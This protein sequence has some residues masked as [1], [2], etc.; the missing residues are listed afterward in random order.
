MALGREAATES[1]T[2][3]ASS[4]AAFA[5]S[6]PPLALPKGGGAIRG[7]G[8]KFA[9]NPVT[10]T[11]SMTVPI[12]TSPGREGFG[13]QFSLTYDSGSGNGHFG[14]GWSL[15]L[16]AI[17]RKTEKGL[18]QYLDGTDSDI[19]LLSGAEDLVPVYR[20]DPDG[21]W[22]AGRVGYQRDADGFWVRDAQGQLVVHEDEIEGYR[23]RRYR[24]RIEGLFARIEQWSR[25]GSLGDVHWRSISKDNILTLYGFDADSRIADPLDASRIFSWLICE[26]RDDK[27]NAI[28]YL[29][30]KE[31][32][33]WHARPGQAD[34]FAQAHQFNRGGRNALGR[35]AQRYLHRVLYGNRVPLLDTQGQRPR[36]LSN[37]PNPPA[38]S[39]ADW[40]FE[41]RFD[42]GEL[43]ENDPTGQP[44]RS[45]FYRPDAFSSYRSGFEIRTC[46]RCERVLMLHHIPDQPARPGF[47]A[48]AGYQ[49]VVRSTEF[50][51]DDELDPA[52][53]TRPIYSFL[54]QAV[55]AGWKHEGGV[56][57][58]VALPPVEFEYTM[59]EVQDLVEEI[60]AQDLS[61]LPIGL[62]GTAYRWTDL[63]GEGVPGILTEQAGAWFYKRNLGPL[64]NS[65][66]FAPLEVVSSKPN[67][68][69]AGGAE[70]MDLAGDGLPDLVVMEG[71]MSGLYEHDHAGGWQPFK[72]FTSR[73]NRGFGNPN[74]K[75]IDLNGDGHADI[76]LSED[77]AFVWHA[78]LAE[79]GF[80]PARR[81]VKALDEEKG[82]RI[83]FADGTQSIYLADLSGD[84]LTDIVRIRQGEVCYW[85]H[86]GH[87]RF[88]AKVTMDNAPWFDHPDQFDHKRIR[89]ADI[90]GSGT[91]DIIYLH[92]DGVCLYFNQSGNSWSQPQTLKAF[93]RIDDV[94]SIVPLD[95]LGNG[96]ACLVWS[97][98]LPADARRPMRYVNLMGGSKP[99][100][101]VKTTNNLGAETRVAYAP[102]TKFYLQDKFAGKPWIT[103]LPFPVHV[104]ERVETLDHVSRN[105][106]VTRYA[107][108]H[109]YFDGE[110]REFRGFGMIEQ[111]DTEHFAALA[112]GDVPADNIAAESHVPPV[113]TKT[114]F[115]T[116]VYLG[117]NHVSDFF[118]GLLNATDPGEYFREPGLTD[119]E[120]RALLLPDAVMPSGLT[121]EEER[122]ACRALKGSMLRQEVYADDAGPNPTAERVRRASTP[123]TVTE[124]NFT[125]RALQPRGDNRHAVFFTYARE[126]ISFH[127]ERNPADPRIQH[128]LTL[129]VDDYGNVLKQAA[130]GYG[131]R[132]QVRVLD[133]QGRVQLVANPGLAGL[134]ADDQAKQTT[135]L[136]TYTEARFTNPVA[137]DD[138]QR[139]PLPS[140]VITYELTRY[141]ASGPAIGPAAD[142]TQQP[143]RYQALDLVEPDPAHP[144]WLRHRFAAPEVAY[145][146]T[147]VGNQRRRPIE[148]LRTLY[149]RDDLTGLLPLGQ[150]QPL[151]LPGES[152]KLAF[153]PDLVTQV[154][155]RS[156]APL[157]PAPGQVLPTD[158]ANAQWASRG[159]YVDLD[160]NGHWWLPSGRSF[161]TEG[162][163]DNAQAELSAA[164]RHFYLPRRYRDPFG[165]N[166]FVDFDDHDL[167]MVET[168]DALNNR[169]TVDAN[170][171]RVLQSRLVSDPNRN[172]TEVA[173]DTLG[174]VV[175]TAVMGKPLPAPVEG[176]S[177]AGFA[178]DLT[179]AQRA[180]FFDAANPHATAATL[181]H[182]AS[183][184]IVYDL[185]RFRRTRQAT[186][187]DPTKWQPACAAT[188]ARETH[189]NAPLPPQG[190]K[191]QLSFSYSD[192]FGREIQKKI[193]AERGPVPQ[194]DGAG[195]I[196]V[197]ADGQPVMTSNDVSPRWVGSGWTV[198]NNKGKP[199]RQYEP[200]F[201]DT[202]RLD[203]DVRIG[204]SPVLFYDPADRVIATLHPN[205][206]FEKVVFDPWQQTTYDVSDTCAPRPA[207]PG[208]S[209]PAQTGDP[210]TDPDI[211]GT[212]KNYFKSQPATWQTWYAQRIG[213]A[214][215]RDERNAAERAA[216]HADTP[217]TAHFDALGR[218]FLTLARNRVVCA[219]HDLNG[220]EEDVATRVELD[221][222]GNQR[223][224]FD[225]R[226]LPDADNL[227]LGALQQRIVMQY[228]YDM[229]GNRIHQLSMEAGARWMLNDVAGKPIRAWDSRGHN[230]TTKYDALRRP[231]EQT[232]RGTFSDPDPLEPNSDPRTLN[233]DILV[234]KIEYGEPPLGATV[235]QETEAQR[236]NLRTRIYR[237]FDSA[238]VA[239]NARLDAGGRPIEAYDFKGNLLRSTRRLAKSYT[240]IPDWQLDRQ[241]EPALNSQLDTEAFE[242]STRYDARNRP[243]QSIGPH[244]SL[245]RPGHPNNINVIQPVFNEANLLERLDVWLERAS[246]PLTLLDPADVNALPSPVGVANI[247]YD[248]KGQRTLIDY[249]TRDATV[250]RNTYAYD[251]ETFRLTHLYTRRGVNPATAQ[252]VAFTDDCEN[253]NPPPAT[254]AAPERPP[255]GKG[256]GLQNLHYTYDPA[257]NITHIRDDAQQTIY[258]CGVVVEPHNDYEYD[259]LY[260]LIQA[261]GRQ[262]L[263]Q[264]GSPIPHSHDDAGR[265]GAFP[266]IARACGP[267]DG[268][269]MGT[270]TERYV[271]DAVG[272]FLK[273]Q[274]RGSNPAHAG[275]TRA[276]S[277]AA[278][279]LI[280]DGHDGAPVK[281]SN[282]LTRTMLNPAGNTQQPE[283]YA[284]DAHGNM[285]RMPHLTRMA[286]DYRDRL[287]LTSRQ[288]VNETPPPDKIQQTTYY[289]YDASGQRVRKVWEKAPGLIEERIY[290]GGF[291]IFRRHGGSI[292]ANTATLERE[293][294]HVM[295]DK[296]RIALVE[297][298]TLDTAGND[299]APRQQIR[300]QL[301]NQLGSACLELDEDA[302]IISYEEYS[303]YGGSTYQA[304]RSQKE[305]AKRCRY[306]G[307]E[308]DEES[309]LYYHGARYYAAWLGR[310][311][312]CDPVGLVEGP[313][314][315][316][317]VG[318]NPV[319][320]HDP[321]GTEKVKS[322]PDPELIFEFDG[323]QTQIKGVE[324]QNWKKAWKLGRDAVM[325]ESVQFDVDEPS[326]VGQKGLKQ[327]DQ[328]RRATSA[329]N[330]QLLDSTTNRVTKGTRV[331]V[332]MSGQKG[333]PPRAPV[334]VADDAAA[335]FTRRFSEVSE[336]NDLFEQAK[337]SLSGRR[338]LTPVELKNQINTEFR[339][340]IREGTSE[341][342]ARVRTALDELG[343]DSA[344]LRP[345]VQGRSLEMLG[346]G[347]AVVGAFLGGYQVGSG[348]NQ[349]IE[350][351]LALGAIDV[352]EGS[353]NLG[354]SIGTTAAVKSGVLVAEAGAAAG[355]LTVAA[356]AAAAAS[357]ALA[358]E[359]A[360]AAV[361]GEPTPIDVAD[362]YY[363]THFGDIAG[364]VA[365]RYS[366]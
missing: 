31:D 114:W 144:G 316:V 363:G 366:N 109:G 143:R 251:R 56:V 343:W 85:P 358:A 364:W 200:F 186:P 5:V 97:S 43:D 296:Q 276:Y 244:S 2:K 193:Q 322:A 289:V 273:M 272:N 323:E 282:R 301:S 84:G 328:Y 262:H 199:V 352:V 255:A 79:E 16:P 334:S 236:L 119:D 124:Q 336:L 148:R 312:G 145:E 318:S 174:M 69:L 237:H 213:G 70:F 184:R 134:N 326:A 266:P 112:W 139:N 234:D 292:S 94:A 356:G 291:E 256:C 284:H 247:D 62:D 133:A 212:V 221:I 55:Q 90:D 21:T 129:E 290:L 347:A 228:A 223:Q 92:R 7:I 136:L 27:G 71:P 52:S 150:L 226:K 203:F 160:G 65:A 104:V 309:G 142:P 192:G 208:G 72:P 279:S 215:G 51:Y 329:H 73:L 345:R 304:V 53:A 351:H 108:H 102:S 189:L 265:S 13:P 107:Y 233:R 357:V 205:H 132:T 154:Y 138:V 89:L 159:G 195:R 117:R 295:D 324:R 198:F 254:I 36:F 365:G 23:V 39:P 288:V 275:W 80:G 110:E 125:I 105:R 29:Y 243:V 341:S 30:K 101:L 127:Y 170:D 246:E 239:I 135:A 310:W 24:P 164:R 166:A 93:P 58:R 187:G 297:T 25:L 68:S 44:E 222:E 91:T 259:A 350:G 188:L 332:P 337:Q 229:L 173:F 146:A 238:G 78:S 4:E 293:T 131:R 155:Q 214:R 253:P 40:L 140:E 61:N 285:Q 11:G 22:V 348:L 249:K 190:L 269:A 330:R 263:G 3:A 202:H 41:V 113:H 267:N 172:Q 207:R 9:A 283:N 299:L 277:Y 88:G 354:L 15:S 335:L 1:G 268:N 344:T 81:V 123:Y 287:L 152:Y 220:T 280:E 210:R 240:A 327:S 342:A 346:K 270:Y 176:D 67:V 307:K 230:F 169:V 165:Q 171:Y 235:A 10:G 242:G 179:Q 224:V 167:L 216:A 286:W 321:T 308:R 26:S 320:Y 204:V 74:L 331:E 151:A 278:D 257:G 219:G 66:H 197:G 325:S 340:L 83:V 305:T 271:Y 64:T 206:T 181:L 42:Y 177:L 106:F 162:P 306:T 87:A 46:R 258:F 218:P 37:L 49:G 175:G 362:K 353:A 211:A 294:L 281:P 115:H 191:I 54:K 118:A 35:T 38:D 178:A 153:T 339:R 217:T 225:E 231:I 141:P 156:G 77:E 20:Q 317:Y 149:R 185:D 47:V 121:L 298:R 32:G 196:V 261:K 232:V 14:F 28:R 303:P 355:T 319:R 147:A 311:A 57:A 250:I 361:K 163:G 333:A 300:Y 12:A 34:P 248:A 264:G 75:F 183:T 209:S 18:P 252:G 130:I 111:W 349:M 360:R 98:P 8:E 122:E 86:L 126:A 201:T 95:L 33:N 99:H 182:G 96:T 315:Y 76:L 194:R 161:F 120:A 274:H 260:R 19:F 50:V 17:A 100:L 45:W 302:H 157:I 359:T 128:A 137:T 241:P 158:V 6:A 63:H 116:G 168:R 82:P 245:T 338:D 314:A 60:D 180:G 313:N 227:P 59:P 48:Q 103:R